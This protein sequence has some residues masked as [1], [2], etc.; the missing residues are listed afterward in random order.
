MVQK[1]EYVVMGCKFLIC[2]LNT[3]N[4]LLVSSDPFYV[5]SGNFDKAKE[6]V[7]KWLEDNNTNSKE[8]LCVY[9]FN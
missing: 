1:E 9:Y 2:G 4:G 6:E 7:D 8:T 5:G 3:K